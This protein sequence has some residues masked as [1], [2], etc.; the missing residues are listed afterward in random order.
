MLTETNPCPSIVSFEMP[1]LLHCL[2]IFGLDF[3]RTF[4]A[5]R[6]TSRYLKNRREFRAKMGDD[7]KWGRQ[8]PILD[9]WEASSGNLGAYFH[10]DLRVAEW[11]YLKQ[12]LRHVDVSNNFACHT[13]LGIIAARK[14]P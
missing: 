2:R 5:V 3:R 14:K 6:G 1:S 13:G 11:I 12:P 7:F 4:H 10:Q 9:E 8:L